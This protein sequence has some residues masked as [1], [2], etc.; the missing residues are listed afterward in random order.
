M[1]ETQLA[2]L[3]DFA[4]ALAGV[5]RAMIDEA[6]TASQDTRSDAN[7][8]PDKT[9]VTATDATIEHRLRAMITA[10]F[11]DHGIIGEEDAPHQKD[12]E[13][14]W[15]LDPIDGTAA[16]IAGIPVYSTLI[17]VCH[18]SRPVIGVMDFPALD[19]RWLGVEG[20]P[21]R[22]NGAPVRTRLG[23]E[24]GGAFL[25]TSNPDIYPSADLKAMKSLREQTA[26]RIYGTAALAYGRLAQGRVDLAIDSGLKIWDILAFVP[27]IQGAGGI[28]TDWTGA[29]VTLA[30]GQQVLAA[31]D[32]ALHVR[33]LEII[34]GEN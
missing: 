17:A 13:F 22:L 28:I 23:A 26:W 21:T 27:V 25:S 24:M 33:A 4:L 30:S 5:S 32:P 19:A 1:P 9:F 16:F 10:Q 20:Q 11:P 6:I 7:F 2:A 29:P 34:A 14:V 31:G 3:T 8:K 12:A 18:N 15:V